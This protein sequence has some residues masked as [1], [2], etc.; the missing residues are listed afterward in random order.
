[1]RSSGERVGYTHTTHVAR[2]S[3]DYLLVIGLSPYQYIFS[4]DSSGH[5]CN[6]MCYK[7]MMKL[8]RRVYTFVAIMSIIAGRACAA[9]YSQLKQHSQPIQRKVGKERVFKC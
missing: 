8:S 5:H 4:A 2:E 1:M 9:M 3:K 7:D 6:H